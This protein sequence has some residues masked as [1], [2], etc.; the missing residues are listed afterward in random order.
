MRAA[1]NRD[2]RDAN[3]FVN[4]FFCSSCGLCELYSCPQGL[5]PRSLMAEYK[6]GLRKAGVK[7]PADILPAPVRESREYRKAPEERLEARLG[8]SAYDREAPIEDEV[9]KVN[10]VAIP[11]SQHIGA[12]AEPVVS[13]GDAVE[14]GQVIA[15][16]AKGLS[17]PIHASVSGRVTGVGG[18]VITLTVS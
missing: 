9:K 2:F 7:P 8:L 17:V 3:P 15:A 14:R 16:A 18:G 10:V 12:P 11:L 1:A 5:A 6:A 4:T 13:V